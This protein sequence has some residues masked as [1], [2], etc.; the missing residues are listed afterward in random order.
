MHY[1]PY[2]DENDLAEKGVALLQ[3]SVRKINY[4]I[5]QS[6]TPKNK[7]VDI[8]FETLDTSQCSVL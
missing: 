4:N 5:S 2:R 7:M 1:L 3:P 6:G 8:N